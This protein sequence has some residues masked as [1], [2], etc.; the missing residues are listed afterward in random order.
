MFVVSNTAAKSQKLATI[1]ADEIDIPT[2]A[3]APA[4]QG[5][6]PFLKYNSHLK[7]CLVLVRRAPPELV[8]D[9]EGTSVILILSVIPMS[10]DTRAASS[11]RVLARSTT[12]DEILQ[13]NGP[14]MQITCFKI[15]WTRHARIAAASS[16]LPVLGLFFD[17]FNLY[18]QSIIKPIV[19]VRIAGFKNSVM[20][21]ACSHRRLELLPWLNASPALFDFSKFGS[22]DCSR[23]CMRT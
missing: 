14:N 15:A 13:K 17:L 5:P 23:A 18:K 6:T 1:Y 7:H 12:L 16:Y 20:E 4:Q 21:Y 2:A 9:L 19:T 3:L 10:R 11:R 8:I 22:Q